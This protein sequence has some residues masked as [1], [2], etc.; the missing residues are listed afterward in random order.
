M[1]FEYKP[2]I[3]VA[4][5]YLAAF[6][7]AMYNFA[8]LE[9][10]IVWL[11]ET[12]GP[13][14][15]QQEKGTARNIGEK[16]RALVNQRTQHE[17]DHSRLKALAATFLTLVEDR[18]ALAHGIPHTAE[19]GEQRLGY[20]RKGVRRDWS[21]EAMLK[22]AKNFENAAIE[23]NSLLHGGRFERHQTMTKP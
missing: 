16:F 13:G 17:R 6:G 15:I 12:I 7:R 23:A 1:S 4:D 8:C 3:P 20:N 14:Y 22:S 2:R 9:W 19:G 10:G 18:N 21:I 5:D 11:A